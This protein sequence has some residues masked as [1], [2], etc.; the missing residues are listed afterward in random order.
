M[1]SKKPGILITGANQGIGFTTTQNLASTGRCHL[2]VG[3][4][5]QEKAD[6]A[7]QQ[8]TPFSLDLTPLAIDVT[9]DASVAAAAKTVSDKFGSLDILINNAGISTPTDHASI[10]LRENLRAV[11]DVNV[12][13]VAVITDAL[14]PLLRASTYHDRRIVNVTT[15]LGHI[16]ITL[17]PTSE[18]SA[19]SFALPIYRS[20]KSALNMITAIDAVRLADEGISAAPGYT[21]TNFTGG[22]GVKEASQAPVQIVRAATE[23]DPREY[24]GTVVDEEG[25]LGEF[26][27]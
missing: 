26:G 25:V 5:S 6:A 13:G 10:S 18:F 16:G 20:S 9:S 27:W 7:V 24:F 22:Y 2:L 1:S 21:R 14:L 12:F 3:A 11:F 17:S 4:R 8:L 23:G 15:G 19:K